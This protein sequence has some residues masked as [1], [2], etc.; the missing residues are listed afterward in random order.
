[1]MSVKK[2]W[3]TKLE[4]QNELLKNQELPMKRG[5]KE[6]K[7]GSLCGKAMIT[8]VL[9]HEK[10]CVW[11]LKNSLYEDLFKKMTRD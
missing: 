11:K 7:G 4:K 10:V 8:I 2:L 3:V 1:M 6:V 5:V 9:S